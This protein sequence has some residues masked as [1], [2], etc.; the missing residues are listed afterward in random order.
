MDP[1]VP[2]VASADEIGP[3]KDVPE[4]QVLEMYAGTWD[5]K[6]TGNEFTKGVD[7]AHWILGGRFLEQSGF[8]VSE[9]GTNLVEIT[10]IYTFV[11]GE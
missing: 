1:C 10:T 6:V 4:L 5:V 2:I 7:T 8:I 9:N 3:A 11:E